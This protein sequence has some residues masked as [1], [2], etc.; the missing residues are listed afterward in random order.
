MADR[1]IV[2]Q[3]S[4]FRTQFQAEGEADSTKGKMEGVEG[5][6]QLN[7]YSMLL[8][9]LGSCTAIVLNTYARYHQLDLE[10]VEI[11]L[12]YNR[13]YKKDCAT[14]EEV[15]N[16]TE[17]VTEEILLKGR[18]SEEERQKL[19]HIAHACPIYKMFKEGIPIKTSLSAQTQATS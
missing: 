15:D 19:L 1:V 2:K 14:C 12:Q 7:P 3:D 11:H 13:N 6:H 8:S 17:E 16:F 9:S 18:L 10:E 4:E 5:I